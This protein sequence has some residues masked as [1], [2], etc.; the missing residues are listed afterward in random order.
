MTRRLLR[1]RFRVCFEAR[2]FCAVL[3]S[4]AG[5]GSLGPE[6]VWAASPGETVFP[7]L[8]RVVAEVDGDV[9]TAADLQFWV[10]QEHL[11]RPE[12]AAAPDSL[13]AAQL[14][15]NLTDEI[16]M[17]HWAEEKLREIDQEAVESATGQA[18]AEFRDLAPDRIEYRDWL[19]EAGYTEGTVRFYLEAREQRLWLIRNALATRHAVRSSQLAG[20]EQTRA[21]RQE[22]PVRVHLRQILLRLPSEADDRETS[23]LLVRALALRREIFAGLSF[24]QA[25]ELYSQDDS[26]RE[27]GGNLGWIELQAIHPA[28]A[29]AVAGLDRYDVSPPIRTPQ[30]FHLLQ[31]V[32]SE[33]PTSL[34]LMERVREV[35]TEILGEQRAQRSVRIA[36]GVAI[37]PPEEPPPSEAVPEDP[38]PRVEN[39]PP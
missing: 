25:A 11:R 27:D 7:V 29:D 28:L 36:E 5:S 8:D 13:L 2:I 38:L 10:W 24:S 18:L 32:D 4:L 6:P 30:G 15:R 1:F 14:L 35:Y 23:R 22:R 3:L 9:L 34:M 26:T 21:A 12:L 19:A 33:T 39:S 37:A 31:L 17:A 20:T 16:L